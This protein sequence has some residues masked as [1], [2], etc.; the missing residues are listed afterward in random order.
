MASYSALDSHKPADNT[1]ATAGDTVTDNDIAATAGDTV[2]DKDTAADNDTGL[3]NM[4]TG[5]VSLPPS[6]EQES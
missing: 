1:A 4:L 5:D 2:T 3:T 6:D